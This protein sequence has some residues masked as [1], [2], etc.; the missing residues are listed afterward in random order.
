[1]PQEA[2]TSFTVSDIYRYFA[3]Q[4]LRSES[5]SRT[6]YLIPTNIIIVLDSYFK[7]TNKSYL[8]HMF[9]YDLI[10]FFDHLVVAYSSE[11]PCSSGTA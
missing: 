11:A 3:G 6:E 7:L 1:M 9:W 5:R 8:I 4:L 10:E 2:L